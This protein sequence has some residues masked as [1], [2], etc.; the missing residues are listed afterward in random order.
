MKKLTV[1]TSPDGDLELRHVPPALAYAL[2]ELPK[3]LSGEF[4]ESAS[5]IADTV[6]TLL[7]MVDDAA[8][9]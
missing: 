2:K 4:P 6:S 3:L 1:V 8:A 7:S 9:I 5:R